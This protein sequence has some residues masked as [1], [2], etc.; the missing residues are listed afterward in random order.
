MNKYMSSIYPFRS[1][2][3]H[4]YEDYFNGKSWLLPVLG[5]IGMGAGLMYILDPDRGRTRRALARDKMK[6][7]VNRTGRAISSKTRDLTNRAQG[8][9]AEVSH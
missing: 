2:H 1:K 9:V 4:W 5:G 7:A 6:S 8:V 3:H